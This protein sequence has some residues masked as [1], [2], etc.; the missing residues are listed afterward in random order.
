MDYEF[1]SVAPSN[2]AAPTSQPKTTGYDFEPVNTKPTSGGT[3][4]FK[5]LGEDSLVKGKK[6]G[7]DRAADVGK[8]FATG[9]GIGAFTPEIL[10]G[11]GLASAAFPLTAPLSPAL[12]TAGQVTRGG[13]TATA[14]STGL[15]SGGSKLA[16]E[17]VDMLGAKDKP[18]AIPGTGRSVPA[19]E[20]TENIVAFGAPAVAGAAKSLILKAPLVHNAILYFKQA[21]GKDNY[22]EAAAR[23]LA[24][25]R[26]RVRVND[27]LQSNRSAARVSEVETKPYRE[28][29]DF[30]QTKDEATQNAVAMQ[31][32][33]AQKAADEVLAQYS[34][35]ANQVITTN[36]NEAQRLINEG[37]A[38][39]KQIIDDVVNQQKQKLGI[40]RRA[41][42]AARRAG[43]APQETLNSIGNVNAT[44]AEIGG[45]LQQRVVRNLSSEQG[46]LSSQ[47]NVDRKVV[48][49]IVA[50]NEARGVG[51]SQT[52]A[53][54]DLRNYLDSRLL[55][56]KFGRE[57]KF[58]PVTESQQ[59]AVYDNILRAIDD[60][61]IF[62][63]ISQEGQPVY[64]QVPTSFEALDHVRRKL[65]EVYDGKAVEGYDGLLKEQAKDLYGKIRKIQVEYT[66]GAYDDVLKKYAEG[67]GAVNQL[68]IPT[69]KKL[70][71][72]DTVN[73][74]YLTYDPSGLPNEFFSSRKKVADL[75]NLT[76]DAGY[77]E[78]QAAN[79]IARSF[80]DKD[81][82]F[83]ERYVFDNKE[84]LDLFP[85]LQS[86]V[87]AHLAAMKRTESV[88]PKSEALAR[89]LRTEVKGIPGIAQKEA[90]AVTKEAGATAKTL[91]Q[92]AK[93]QAADIMREGKEEAKR[94]SASAKQA[95][96]LLGKGDPV[97]EM[98][99]IIT[100]GETQRLIAIAPLIKES[101]KAMQDF[102]R[103][104][105]ITLSRENPTG[106]YDKWERLMRPALTN[107]GLITEA[108][109]ANISKRINT[110]R[111]TL[112][113]SAAAQTMISIIRNGATAKLAGSLT[114]E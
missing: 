9:A 10:T 49:D 89:S 21:G 42:S 54:A 44:N 103:A 74:E 37:D 13:R 79:H 76:R 47:Y 110:V 38:R 34:A 58:A 113:P 52:A 84:W 24:N 99:K 83:V 62:M 69:G 108:E 3:Y 114:G 25:F 72:T 92:D 4:D 102:D 1:E 82:K 19:G 66:N 65:G 71:K 95:E 12:L 80:K 18:I 98:E 8:A 32:S 105:R 70:T 50:Q 17:T 56:G 59:R 93:R 48:N 20:F 55:K 26:N 45:S 16:G 75:I 85:G 90:A 104:L 2:Q 77:V 107:T 51:V 53:Y 64:R 109:A 106:I 112:E 41:E 61:Q 36:R 68:G 22:S 111:L 91:E 46:A 86:R 87:N 28:L 81:A 23:E 67:K 30:I 97:V 60:Q 31:L 33:S 57:A 11:L 15:F 88:V 63:G 14:L 7:L 29:F 101:P 27:L 40:A 100:S 73:P 5:A 43:V 96:S 94:L 39:A 78:Q 6:T 35:R